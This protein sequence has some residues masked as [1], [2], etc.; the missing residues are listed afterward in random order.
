MQIIGMVSRNEIVEKDGNEYQNFSIEGLTCLK[1]KNLNGQE[2]PKAGKMV[3]ATVTVFY[4]PKKAPLHF[5]ES[6]D[7]L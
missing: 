6:W 5:I 4:R 7:L 1:G 3:K 2:L